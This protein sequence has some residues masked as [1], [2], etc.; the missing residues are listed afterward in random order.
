MPA[1]FYRNNFE[2]VKRGNKTAVLF[3]GKEVTSASQKVNIV[4]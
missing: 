1:D 3:K 2:Q 4:F